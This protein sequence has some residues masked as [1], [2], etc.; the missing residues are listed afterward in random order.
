[1]FR[2]DVTPK[3]VRQHD[4]YLPWRGSHLVMSEVGSKT[5]LVHSATVFSSAAALV[6]PTS[7]AYAWSMKCTRGYGT[8]LVWNSLRST[9]SA[10][11]KR[12]DAVS[13]EVTCAMRRLRLAYDGESSS[14]VVLAMS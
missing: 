8:R 5:M 12:S 4:M 7:G 10:P 14:R 13:D 9:L 3:D 2:G 1:M 11:S 6:A